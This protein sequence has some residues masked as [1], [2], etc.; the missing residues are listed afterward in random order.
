MVI[1]RWGHHPR[2]RE[3]KSVDIQWHRIVEKEAA[4]EVFKVVDDIAKALHHPPAAWIPRDQ[5]GVEPFRIA[6]GASLAFGS[7]GIALFY[8]YLSHVPGVPHSFA[9]EA[10]RYISHACDAIE[11]V[12]MSDGLYRGISGIAWTVQHLQGLLYENETNDPETDPNVEIDRILSAH[13]SKV[14]KFDLWKG[15]IGLGVYALERYPHPA[16]KKLL[17]LVVQRLDRLSIP[18]D[19]G[20]T[21]FNPP[22]KL[23]PTVRL[24]YPKGYY[25]LGAA[26]GT[27][28]AISFLSRAHALGISKKI[29]RKLLYGAVSWLLS[30]K[31][32]GD[33]TLMFPDFLLPPDNIP[34]SSGTFGWCHGEL[35]VAAAL[36]SAADNAAEPLWK[37]KAIE[38]AHASVNHLNEARNTKKFSDATLCHGTAG[39]GHMFNR[40]YQST[41]IEVFKEE[42]CKWFRETIK[43]RKPG[44]IAGF[45][46]YGRSEDGDM[47]ELYD[48]GFIQ[49]AAG[50]GLALLAAVTSLEPKWDRVMLISA[51]E[52]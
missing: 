32:E 26:H 19:H 37:A 17:E 11:A 13:M 9:D 33:S 21:W 43:M 35:G 52:K 49:G 31:R 38:A 16:A 51:P 7:S 24:A 30:Q 25:D 12:P 41:G 15:C 5:N 50:I 1:E 39:L 46:K 42:A 4:E 3:R 44:G 48:P 20:I 14:E 18:G 47:D 23:R 22:E 36:L 2:R 6:R 10:D 27:A 34:V 40:I 28:G 45:S 29:T 8:T